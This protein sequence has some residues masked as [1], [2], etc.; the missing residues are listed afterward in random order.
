MEVQEKVVRAVA[1]DWGGEIVLTFEGEGRQNSAADPWRTLPGLDTWHRGIVNCQSFICSACLLP[2]RG[3]E[4]SHDN[5]IHQPI[6]SSLNY[7]VDLTWYHPYTRYTCP[8]IS[9]LYLTKAFPSSPRFQVTNSDFDHPNQAFPIKI[10]HCLH[11][12]QPAAIS[13]LLSLLSLSSSSS[14]SCSPFYQAHSPRSSHLL[15]SSYPSYNS[16]LSWLAYLSTT[17]LNFLDLLP[18]FLS[19]LLQL[20]FLFSSISSSKSSSTFILSSSSFYSS[21]ILSI[22]TSISILFNFLVVFH[23]SSSL[24]FSLSS[25]IS[26]LVSSHTTSPSQL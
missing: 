21:I 5:R 12:R 17:L 25:Y 15:R 18:S 13:S 16:S 20:Y 2:S 19:S 7:T 8:I 11:S 24:Y 26:V 14:S 6:G 9:S 10:H 3:F 1:H 23:I 22:Y 4:I